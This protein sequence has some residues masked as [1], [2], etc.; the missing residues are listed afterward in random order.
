MEQHKIQDYIVSGKKPQGENLDMTESIKLFW[1]QV[2]KK[3]S[4]W[5]PVLFFVI[6][7][8]GYSVF[9]RTIGIDDMASDLYVGSGH[10]MIS[11]GRWGMNVLTALAAIPR[12]SPASDRLLATAVLLL[13]GFMLSALFFHIHHLPG[14]KQFILKY[15]VLSCFLITYPIVGEIWEYTGANYMSTGG[16]LIS[17]VSC[18][19]I[20]TREPVRIKDLLLVGALMT[21]P[22]SSYE[23]GV[24]FYI[25]LVCSVL[26]YK[27]CI[28]QDQMKRS[29]YWKSA[30]QYVIP[31]I[32]ALLLRLAIASLLR[33]SMGVAKG[34]TGETEITWGKGP[35]SDVFRKLIIDTFLNYIVNGLVY[36]PITIFV[37]A[38]IFLIIFSIVLTIKNRN[39]MSLFGGLIL[40]VSVFTLTFIQG[41]FM[42]YR[43]AIPLSALTSFAAFSFMELFEG[44]KKNAIV[45]INCLACYMLWVQSA[46]LNSELALNNQRSE[47]EMRSMSILAQEILSTNPEKPVIFIGKHNSGEYFKHAK[48]E[49]SDTM[50]GVFYQKV[51]D[52]FKDRYGDYYYTFFH[53]TEFP[54]SNVNSSI[55]YS[56]TVEGM[57]HDYLAYLGYDIEVIDREREPELLNKAYEIARATGMKPYEVQEADDFII[58]SLLFW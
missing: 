54:D 47:N 42:Q 2:G 20:E 40:C 55:N 58:A 3:K 14:E 51:I 41:R 15:T 18:I 4:Y 37:I 57:M 16:M 31:L 11:A 29:L 7:S 13:S 44:K 35:I 32:V 6:A 56:V 27:Y 39:G 30:L 36:L 49:Y 8:Y 38:E 5:I 25:T 50:A 33:L 22:M 19:Y 9:S 24:L 10:E 46:Y 34:Q 12:P 43:T 17:I 53:L 48:K 52:A 28:R 21:L 26:F 1:E 45:I 23:S